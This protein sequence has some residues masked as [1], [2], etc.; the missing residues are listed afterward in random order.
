MANYSLIH[1]SDL[2]IGE[3]EK[4]L[5]NTNQIVKSIGKSY[6]GIPV[7]ITGDL[8]NSATKEQFKT[9]REIL[10]QLAKT[11]PILAV[12]GNHDYAWWGI[13]LRKSGW[14]NWVKYL[15][16]PL[17]WGKDDYY[18]MGVDYEPVG[19]DGLGVFKHKSCVYFGVDSGDPND[20]VACAEGWISLE[21]ANRL[22]DSLKKY[23]GKTRIVLLHHHPFEHRLLMAL[24]GYKRLLRAVKDNCELLLFGHK[25][26]YGIWWNH[27]TVPLIVSSHKSSKAMSGES[28]M[29]T[30]IEINGAG[31]P[32]VSFSH[33]LKVF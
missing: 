25:H 3:S 26:D 11:N 13:S 30:I 8:T 5:K 19:I 29:G 16:T 7:L 9:M 17:G 22:E 15:G 1:L 18:W 33:R 23:E 10:N 28:L 4:E 2:H 20:K 6:Q 32:N 31:T 24:R 27:K 21:L 12:P 14:E